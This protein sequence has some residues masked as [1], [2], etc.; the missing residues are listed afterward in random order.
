MD[1]LHAPVAS[2]LEFVQDKSVIYKY[3]ENGPATFEGVV[4]CGIVVQAQIASEPDQ[5]A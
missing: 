2:V 5:R 3:Y 4:Q 1:E